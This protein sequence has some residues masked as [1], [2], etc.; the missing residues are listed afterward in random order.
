M[1]A[2]KQSPSDTYTHGHSGSVLRSHT[3]RTVQNS[4]AYLLP[5]LQEGRSILD[6]GCG[7]GT[8]TL[9]MA[10][11]VGSGEVIG[12]DVGAEV[13]AKATAAIPPK[14]ANV[15]FRRA[16]VYELEFDDDQ[17]D[18]VH[19]HQV[20]QHL[21]DPVAALREMRRVCRPGGVVAVRDADYG[22]MAWAP[23][24]GVL[25]QWMSM[26]QAVARGN[27][28]EP[29]AA[30]YLKGWAAEAGFG[31]VDCSASIWCFADDADRAWWGGLWA[32][33]ILDSSLAEQ[34][35]ERGLA[36]AEQLAEMSEAFTQWIDSPGAWFTVPHGEILA[37]P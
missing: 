8:I 23:A 10:T 1:A 20:L 16:S 37:R 6:V 33:R 18:I 14:L 27:D 26:Y 21:A 13:I 32:G 28:A 5:E 17:F 29:D 22:S 25:D 34:A 30:R 2:P 7:P 3:W 36:T 19:A 24:D 35:L 9:D 4:A 31:E 11:R 15:S 12:I